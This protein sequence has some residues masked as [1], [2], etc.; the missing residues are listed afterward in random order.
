MRLTKRPVVLARKQAAFFKVGKGH[1]P[2]KNMGSKRKNDK[3]SV[4]LFVQLCLV[5]CASTFKVYANVLL[6]LQITQKMNASSKCEK[7][8]IK[9]I[10]IV[11][12]IWNA[13]FYCK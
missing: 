11:S 9:A 5:E 2:P 12:L 1:A 4:Q 6:G 10:E 13:D 3:G 8:K 7:V